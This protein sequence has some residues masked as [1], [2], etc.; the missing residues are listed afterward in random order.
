MPH[1]YVEQRSDTMV[2]RRLAELLRDGHRRGP[3]GIP[4]ASGDEQEVGP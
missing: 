2:Y 1:Q 4:T 3:V